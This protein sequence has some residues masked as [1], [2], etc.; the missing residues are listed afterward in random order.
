MA[1]LCADVWLK[2]TTSDLWNKWA[3][4]VVSL[5]VACNFFWPPPHRLSCYLG[6]DGSVAPSLRLLGWG[7]SWVV[8]D[9]IKG[10]FIV[11]K[12]GSLS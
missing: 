9:K 4:H 7:T 1:C 2:A 3:L 12:R 10:E 11:D 6:S 5:Y 8:L